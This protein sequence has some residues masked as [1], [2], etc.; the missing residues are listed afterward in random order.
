MSIAAL[1]RNAWVIGA[2]ALSLVLTVQ[3]F[4][5]T[6]VWWHLA[7]GQHI[8][9]QGIPAT[10]PF[11]FLVAAHPWVGAQWL[12]EVGLTGAVNLG[13]PGLASLIMGIVASSALL[14]AV[15]SI[16]PHRRPAGPWLAAALLLSALVAAQLVGVRGQVISL[17]GAAVVLNVLMRWRA[18]ST[19][20]L[21]VLPP[22]FALWANLHAGFIIG[23]AILA[24]AMLAVRGVDTRSRVLLAAAVAAS[25][26]ATLLNPSGPG[27]WGYVASTF[28]NSTLTGVVVEW[29][30]PD[31][32]STWGIALALWICVFIAAVARGR[33]RVSRRDLIVAVPMLLLALWA[34]RNITIAPLIGLPVVARAFA[35]DTD[36]PERFSKTFLTA[37]TAVIV[38]IGVMVGV[39]A[40]GESDFAVG[41]YPVQSMEYIAHHDLLGSRIFTDDAAAGYVILAYS[42]EQRVFMDDRY[43]MYP[44]KVINS[45]FTVSEGL[46]G[47]NRAL[48]R[49]GVDVVVWERHSPLT[50]LLD[51]SPA[52]KRVHTDATNAVWVRTG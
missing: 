18:G 11:S 32:R 19:R 13:G 15:L 28:G 8:L 17:L 43:D 6:D 38:L 40:A 26:L 20:A 31:F 36:A 29:Q 27:L 9:A 23:L 50:S 45:F 3:P 5:D 30:S 47:W 12:Y 24:L 41:A 16:P 49:Y 7:V 46:P 4:R 35:V 14:I 48:D 2:A 42:P 10:E 37:V 34:L 51:N 33:H 1:R 39:S 22:V 52:W 25:A 21:L 44:T